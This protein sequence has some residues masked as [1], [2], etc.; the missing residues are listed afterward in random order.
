MAA[1]DGARVLVVD[2]EPDTLRMLV[3]ALAMHQAEVV[4]A[5]SA[6]AA[7]A[8]LET[9]DA[10]VLVS[11]IRMPDKDGYALIEAV[12][13]R[14]ARCRRRRAAVALT[15]DAGV[16]NRERARRAGFDLHL[17]K[18]V[19]LRQLVTSLAA[20]RPHARPAAH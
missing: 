17:A 12:R 6:D 15:A 16:G 18:P 9:F 2:D 8:A 20:L 3:A 13:R 11:D 4:G 14:D 5:P 19:D 7:L 10:D 1:A